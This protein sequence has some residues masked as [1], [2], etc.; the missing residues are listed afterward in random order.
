MWAHFQDVQML[1]QFF[2][3]FLILGFSCMEE[4]LELLLLE[5]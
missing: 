4:S 1:T 2:G 5:L 3:Q